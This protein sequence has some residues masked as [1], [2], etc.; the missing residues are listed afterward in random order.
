MK[1][2]T[3]LAVAMPIIA[4]A[5]GC[6]LSNGQSTD[7]TT[8]NNNNNSSNNSTTTAAPVPQDSGTWTYTQGVITK[9]GLLIVL[10]PHKNTFNPCN[11]ADYLTLANATVTP[12]SAPCAPPGPGAP[13]NIHPDFAIS[14]K[15]FQNSGNA[16][17]SQI[18]NTILNSPD[19]TTSDLVS[20]INSGKITSVNQLRSDPRFV[21]L[22]QP[23]R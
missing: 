7:T 10:G 9:Q 5:I 17:T 1:F 20:R 12:N 8:T 19:S 23:A 15:P 13:A 22:R 3:T 14:P 21:R 6:T 2:N 16:D 11:S 4:S 18:L